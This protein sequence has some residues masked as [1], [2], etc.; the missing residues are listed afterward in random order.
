MDLIKQVAHGKLPMLPD[1]TIQLVDVRDCAS[2]HLAV[3][4]NPQANGRR[5]L[6]FGAVCR[7]PEIAAA[8]G[9]TYGH[10]G[11]NPPVR[12]APKWLMWAMKFANADIAAVYSRIGQDTIYAPQHPEVFSYQY[13]D[14]IYMVSDTIESLI[15]HGSLQK[16]A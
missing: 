1:T 15:H 8:I 4:Q 10:R 11:F 9:K 12:I 3:M 13:T 7:F 16:N 6:S 2:M 14:M 5:H